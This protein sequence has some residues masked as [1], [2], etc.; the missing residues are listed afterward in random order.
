MTQVEIANL[1]LS[2]IAGKEITALDTA[3]AQGRVCL[4]WFAPARDEA[5]ASH[6]WNFATT[7]ARLTL[8]WTALSG[9]ALADNGAG[10]IRVTATAHGLTTGQRVHI[11]DVQGVPNAIGSWYVTV[12]NSSSYD[13]QDSTFSGTHTSGTGSWILAPLFGWDYR[14]ALP[15]DFIRVN[16]LNGLEGNDE[17]SIPYAVEAGVLLCNDDEV[18]ISYVYQHTTYASWPQ[19]FINAFACLLASYIAPEL[20]VSS[21]KGM[22]MRKQYEG[23]ISPQ[24]KH[25]D[26][27][28]GKG[29]RLL[30]DYDSQLVQSRRGIF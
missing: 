2:L 9:V 24:A 10:L 22:E 23:M 6:P 25:R 1:A 14:F 18:T 28:Q 21:S 27:R 4:K 8:T 11:K 7:R 17:D 13:L 3:T 30:P 12:I 5:L 19:E 15:S 26:S 20:A 29:R 16:K